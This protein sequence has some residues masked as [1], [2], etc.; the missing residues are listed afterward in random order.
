[1]I[2]SEKP[3]GWDGRT[4]LSSQECKRRVEQI[5]LQIICY[6]MFSGSILRSDLES[7]QDGKYLEEF[8]VCLEVRNVCISPFQSLN[9]TPRP[10]WY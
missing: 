6:K 9:D 1:M 2:K 3:T 8:L 5:H 10:E 7:F 4:L